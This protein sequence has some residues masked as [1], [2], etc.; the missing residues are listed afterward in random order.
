MI[1]PAKTK[2]GNLRLIDRSAFE[3]YLREICQDSNWV[4]IVL[5]IEH[6]LERVRSLEQN[7]TLHGLLRKYSKY[8][9]A[10]GLMN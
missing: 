1:F 10:G 3:A 4:P 9:L 6:N 5:R 2:D 8:L 7:D